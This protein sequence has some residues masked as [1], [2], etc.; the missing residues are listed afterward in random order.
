MGI[1]GCCWGYGMAI[2]MLIVAEQ[3]LGWHKGA[4]D[5][6]H[7]EAQ[8]GDWVGWVLFGLGGKTRKLGAGGWEVCGVY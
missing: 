4:H 3:Q 2:G 6:E 5:C 1:I 7:G 8:L